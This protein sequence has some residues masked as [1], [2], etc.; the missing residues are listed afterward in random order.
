MTETSK[1]PT[2]KLVSVSMPPATIEA[3]KR[4]AVEGDR[5]FSAEVRIATRKYVEAR[6]G[7]AA[8]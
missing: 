8:A 4:L 1:T 3:M 7:S 2:L 5:S 6:E